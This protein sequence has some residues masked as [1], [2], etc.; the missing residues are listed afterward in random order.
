VFPERERRLDNI[1]S[2]WIDKRF[3]AIT[4]EPRPESRCLT[5]NR[6]IDVTS[7]RRTQCIS[8]VARH[9]ERNVVL[10]TTI[11]ECFDSRTK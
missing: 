4:D 5:P 3:E 7:D 1:V 11:G 8:T 9:D 2:E 6:L 10:T